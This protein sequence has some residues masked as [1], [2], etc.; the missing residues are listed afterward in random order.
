MGD[1]EQPASPPPKG[2]STSQTTSSSDLASTRLKQL[3]SHIQVPQSSTPTARRRRKPRTQT[4]AL[5]PDYSDI[6]SQLST[7]RRL[8]RTPQPSNQA[9]ARQKTSGKL[10]VR[11]RISALLDPDT[12]FREIGSVAGSIT[13]TPS[14]K[15]GKKKE[16]P[17]AFTPTNNLNGL[18]KINGRDIVL[19]ADDFTV[20]AGHADGAIMAKTAY[21]EKLSLSMKLPMVKLVDGSSGGGSVTTIKRDGFSYIPSVPFLMQTV[22]ALNAGIPNLAAI[23][24][25]A[26]GLGAARAVMCHFSVMAADVGSLINAGPEVVRGATGEEGLSTQDLGGWGVHGRNGTVDNIAPNEQGCFEQI[27]TVLGYLPNWGGEAPP[28]VA[29]EDPEDR[30]DVGLRSIIP[31]RKERMYDPR[32]IIESVVDRGSWFEIGS[33]W[34]RT[35][36]GG[37]ARL[38]GRPVGILSLNC[39]VNGGALDAAGSQKLTRLLK[40]CDVMNLPIIQFLDIR[41]SNPKLQIKSILSLSSLTFVFP[42][43]PTPRGHYCSLCFPRFR[44]TALI[45]HSKKAGYAIGTTAER[46]ATMRHGIELA[47]T[48]FTTTTPIFNILIRRVFGVAGNVMLDNRDPCMRVAWPSGTWGSLPLDGGIEVGHRRELREV[49]KDEGREGRERRYRELE[50]EYERLMNPV[51]TAG[52]FGV[53]EVIDPKGTRGVVCGW[54]KR[55]YEVEMGGRVEGRRSGRVVARFA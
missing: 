24:G 30:E 50:G 48:Y 16:E 38:G 22:Q 23:V 28:V 46:T 15:D 19:T 27:R 17:T 55:V 18:G 36:I 40:F 34:G 10:W 43:I 41:K 54:V 37:L 25:P 9:Y 3:S 52:A 32:K 13:W 33:L 8:A 35:A 11:E 39:E 26:V 45:S 4:E 20:R 42:I 6:L 31:R 29:C 5:P 53:E 7:L 49:E 47:K 21:T 14:P 1:D 44:I 12:P 2:D 51:R